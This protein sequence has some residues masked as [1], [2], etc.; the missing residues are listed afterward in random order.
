[1]KQY[2]I[3]SDVEMPTKM[4]NSVK[5]VA[6]ISTESHKTQKTTDWCRISSRQLLQQQQS[7]S[8][9]LKQPKTHE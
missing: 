4:K 8:L 7:G 6:C 9:T 2:T 3:L 1:M 5:K